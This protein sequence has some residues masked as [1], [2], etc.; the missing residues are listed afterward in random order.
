MKPVVFHPDA[1]AELNTAIEFYEHQR[2]GLGVDL[3]SE[4]ENAVWRVRQNPRRYP[5]YNGLG[6]RKCLIKRFPYILF[7]LEYKKTIWIAAVA[8]QMRKP[9]YWMYRT[10][11]KN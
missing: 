6:I 8:H 7:Y 10:P 5:R 1:E 4:V 11:G 2:Q 9:G 3:N